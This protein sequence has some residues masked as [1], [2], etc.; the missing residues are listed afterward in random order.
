MRP[1]CLDTI[2]SAICYI[3]VE[4]V[5]ACLF[6]VKFCGFVT[7]PNVCYVTFV[8][9]ESF[10]MDAQPSTSSRRRNEE[11]L[12]PRK[13]RKL[14]SFSQTE[15]EMI[16]NAYKYVYSEKKT[17]FECVLKTAEI[18]NISTASIY[19]VLKEH[20]ENENFN[21]PKIPGPKIDFKNKLDDFTL[22][23]IR[24]KVHQFFY[25]NESPSLNKVMLILFI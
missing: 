4:F 1:L 24:R 3:F 23:A 20:K 18:L 10:M 8:F 11:T 5:S 19:N 7:L 22:S 16:M 9:A 25:R 15:K 2:S 6:F 12:S 14:K 21:S 17:E 13:K